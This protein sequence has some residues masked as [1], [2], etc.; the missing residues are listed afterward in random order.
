MVSIRASLLHSRLKAWSMLK[1][2]IV[3]HN[4]LLVG[5]TLPSSFRNDMRLLTASQLDFFS[6]RC[7]TFR[8]HQHQ[9][10][11][12]LEKLTFRHNLVALRK[13]IFSVHAVSR[14]SVYSTAK[15]FATHLLA[16][17]IL[18]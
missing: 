10:Q 13:K 12:H 14:C 7:L 16:S 6:K 15:Y 17:E 2:L 18:F 3:G 1:I 4:I 8:R 11:H 9:K 5:T